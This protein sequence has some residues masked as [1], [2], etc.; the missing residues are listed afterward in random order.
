MISG[1]APLVKVSE[2]ELGRGDGLG[3][4]ALFVTKDAV[5]HLA[6]ADDG[7]ERV[8]LDRDRLGGECLR[9]DDVGD[10]A[11]VEGSEGGVGVAF[12]AS[13][14]SYTKGKK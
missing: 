14:V 1:V 2:Y 7:G 3:R 12:R 6:V 9:E 10:V 13:L 5:E 4:D 11:S 8:A